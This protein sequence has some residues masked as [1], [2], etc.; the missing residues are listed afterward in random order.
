M[1]EIVE[2][3]DDHQSTSSGAGTSSSSARQPAYSSISQYVSANTMECVLFASRVLT[4]FFAINYMIPFLGLVPPHSAYYKIFAASAATF[5]LRLHTRIQG[6]FAMNAQFVQ[7]LVIEDA[8]HY[9]VYSVVFLMSAPISMAA[10]P[11]TIYA[12]LHACTFV[13]KILRET[14]HN[15]S[16][17]PKLEQ[18]TAHQTQNA[19][20]IIACS[21]IFLI[22]LLVSLI[23]SGQGSLFLPFAYYRFLSLRYASRR[24]PSTRQAFSQMR[25]SLQNVAGSPSCPGVIS[26]F[27]Y[28]AIDFISARAPPVM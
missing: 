7:R 26:A 15:L 27:I 8:F 10:L 24:N 28:R 14:G 4:V 18:F 25:G 19:L 3:P 5:A 2:E 21:E 6:Q 1:V 20:G 17:V 23:F 9:L 13:T 11:V 16:L 22:P 12:A